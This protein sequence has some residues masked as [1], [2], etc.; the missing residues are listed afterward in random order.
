MP[1]CLQEVNSVTLSDKKERVEKKL[2][3]EVVAL[4][5]LHLT[6]KDFLWVFRT[7]D[8]LSKS[9]LLLW[10]YQWALRDYTTRFLYGKQKRHLM[11][12]SKGS[13]G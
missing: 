8:L 3:E 12:F 2:G 10:A 1:P 13:S 11:I 7:A 9:E 4:L 6:M 5:K